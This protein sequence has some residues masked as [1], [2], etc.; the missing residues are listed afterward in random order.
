MN[1]NE[2]VLFVKSDMF[3]LKL[4]ELLIHDKEIFDEPIGWREK[5]IAESP[6]VTNFGNVWKQI[7][8]TYKMELSAL[9]YTSIPD[10]AHVAKSFKKL[11]KLVEGI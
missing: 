2:C 7:R 5:A 6:L 3:N 11:V 1:D 10:E 8:S 9:A 4:K